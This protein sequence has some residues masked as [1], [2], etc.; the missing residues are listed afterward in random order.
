MKS[1]VEEAS[2]IAK[3][4]ENA[5]IRAGKPNIFQVK[6]LEEPKRN[7]LGLTAQSAKIG[8]FYDYEA[9]ALEKP[10]EYEIVREKRPQRVEKREAKK[11]EFRV[12]W[13]ND[14]VQ[15]TK[16][17]LTSSLH[18]MGRSQVPFS[19]ETRGYHLRIYFEVPVIEDR[20]KE[21]QLFRCLA[22][23][24][25]QALRTKFKKGFAGLKVVLKSA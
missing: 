7:F 15:T 17:W 14:M 4:I 18:A 13:T 16:D 10:F 19:I 11:E 22:Y 23:L 2:S 24:I 6:I 21:Q 12:F 5:W 20:T 3:A 8:F 25:M 9:E 1:I